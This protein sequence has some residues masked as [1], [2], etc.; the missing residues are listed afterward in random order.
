MSSPVLTIC[1]FVVALTVVSA[2][3]PGVTPEV[4]QS[5]DNEV[6]YKCDLEACFKTCQH[7]KTPPPCPSI[8][9]GC[10][11]P[12]CIC[13]GGYLRNAEGKC[14]PENQCGNFCLKFEEY[15]SCELEHCYKTCEHLKTPPACPS[16][17]S[18]CYKPACICKEGTLR[19]SGGLCVPPEEC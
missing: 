15:T 1:L 8:A 18:Y 12:A 13:K 19:N 14:V 5:K 6:Y 3:P 11:S 9:A 4:C 17:S 16:I 7:L 10:F 2:V